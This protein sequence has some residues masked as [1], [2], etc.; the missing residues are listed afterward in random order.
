MWQAQEDLRTAA[1]C[2]L[3]DVQDTLRDTETELV[4]CRN[5]RRDVGAWLRGCASQGGVG[6]KGYVWAH[7]WHGLELQGVCNSGGMWE[8]SSMWAH[9][10]GGLQH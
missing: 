7:G 1:I 9:G 6:A 4:E 2:E 5:I 3:E 10:S 8:F